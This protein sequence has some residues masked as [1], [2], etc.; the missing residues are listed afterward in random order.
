MTFGLTKPDMQLRLCFTGV[1]VAALLTA[2]PAPAWGGTEPQL[3]SVPDPFAQ[4]TPP[5]CGLV[6]SQVKRQQNSPFQPLVAVNPVDPENIVVAY[7]LDGQLTQ[8]IRV[9]KNA[10]VDWETKLIPGLTTCTG[11]TDT[12]ADDS[13]LAFSADPPGPAGPTLYIVSLAGNLASPRVV[14]SRST[15]GGLTWSQPTQLSANDGLRSHLPSVTTHPSNPQIAYAVFGRAE[16]QTGARGALYFLRTDDGGEHWPDPSTVYEALTDDGVASGV[17]AREARVLTNADGNL[18]TIFRRSCVANPCVQ[19]PATGQPFPDN[20]VFA[21]VSRNGGTDWEDPVPIGRVTAGPGTNPPRASDPDPPPPY[22]DRYTPSSYC[23]MATNVASAADAD[24]TIYTVISTAHRLDT[25][26]DASLRFAQSVSLDVYKSEDGSSWSKAS[27]LFGSRMGLPTIAVARDGTVGMTYFQLQSRGG[28]PSPPM[29]DVWYARSSDHGQS[30]VTE[31]LAGPLDPSTSVFLAGTPAEMKG[32]AD[33]DDLQPAGSRGF[34]AVYEM[35]TCPATAEPPGE[36]GGCNGGLS[37]IFYSDID[38]AADLSLAIADAP[39]PVSVGGVLTYTLEVTN[40]GPLSAFSV[41]LRDLLPKSVRLR[42]ADS[43]R[44]N[45]TLLGARTVDCSLTDLASGETATVTIAVRP[46]K[47]G[48]IRN[49]ATAREGAHPIDVDLSN[50]SAT[51]TTE[52][53]P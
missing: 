48:T 38:N 1:L 39:D 28:C 4:D 25:S 5:D 24:G 9:T 41:E 42:S 36:P 31:K 50:N 45:C 13:S 12:I 3:V 27:S 19:D 7:T 14:V 47:K 6:D 18:V 33:Y 21:A 30:W 23:Y 40:S 20:V 8:L 53:T 44:G 2:L 26:V 17:F 35:T 37:D 11:G 43:D 10:G 51:A 32:I 52:V 34:A 22:R 15:D 29:T 46:I 49:T 16:D